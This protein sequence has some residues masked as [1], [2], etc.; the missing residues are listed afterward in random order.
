MALTNAE[1]QRR[2]RE[3]RRQERQQDAQAHQT[4]RYVT[5]VE[6]GIQTWTLTNLD[7]QPTHACALIVIP[8]LHARHFVAFCGVVQRVPSLVNAL[9]QR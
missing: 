4:G 3:R 9:I 2:W 7:N 8:I 5:S 1:R 6:P